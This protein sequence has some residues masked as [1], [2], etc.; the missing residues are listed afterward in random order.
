MIPP[1]LWQLLAASAKA[2][3]PPA[4]APLKSGLNGFRGKRILLPAGTSHD[5]ANGAI[6]FLEVVRP[7]QF[8]AIVIEVTVGVFRSFEEDLLSRGAAIDKGAIVSPVLAVPPA[9]DL[10]GAG[11][12]AFTPDQTGTIFFF[13]FTMPCVAANVFFVIKRTRR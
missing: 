10:G 1:Q 2:G 7:D 11:I 3:Y 8:G 13:A 9:N 6:L 12:N 4:T 5:D